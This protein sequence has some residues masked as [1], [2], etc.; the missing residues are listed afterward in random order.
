MKMRERGG[1]E[2]TSIETLGKVMDPGAIVRKLIDLARGPK[3][4]ADKRADL[5]AMFDA[6][7]YLAQLSE[8][9][10]ADLDPLDH[11]LEIGWRAGLDP[12]PRFST[13]FYLEQNADVRAA[14]LN[15]LAHYVSTGW[16]EGRSPSPADRGDVRIETSSVIVAANGF[17]LGAADRACVEALFD[18]AHYKAQLP[19]GC[20]SGWDPLGHYLLNWRDNGAAPCAEFDPAFYLARNPDVAAAGQ[21]PFIH[22]ALAGKAEGRP[23][24]HPIGWRARHL[25]DLSSPEE[26]RRL[27]LSGA[28][29]AVAAPEE[30]S[31]RIDRAC[32]GGGAIIVALSHDNYLENVGGL[33]ACVGIEQQAFAG[34]GASYLQASPAQPLPTLARAEIPGDLVLTLTLDGETLGNLPAGDLAT[35]LS[36]RR[37]EAVIVHSLL[38]FDLDS[39]LLIAGAAPAARRYF[40]V[41]DYLAIC[42][43]YNLMRNDLVYCGAPPPESAACGVCVYG[44]ERRTTAA[45]MRAFFAAFKPIAIA[46]SEVAANI[47][48]R[49]SGCEFED[50]I[51]QAHARMAPGRHFRDAAAAAAEEARAAPARIA[52]LGYPTIAKGWPLFAAALARFG[53]DPRYEFHHFSAAP[54][55]SPARHHEVRVSADRQDAMIDALIE[56]N[57]D[58]A[59]VLS[60]WPETFCIT[61]H[62]AVAAGA[63]LVA[64]EAGG[65]AAHLAQEAG[66]V[67]AGEAEL[68]DLLDGPDLVEA[69]RARRLAGRKTLALEFS[70]MTADRFASTAAAVGGVRA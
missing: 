15:P 17:S 68:L 3:A 65:A 45:A 39:V 37:V 38:G 5:M 22:Y 60:A 23:G 24:A 14:D 63:I 11:Y 69:V 16:K 7:Y 51:V 64:H 36:A 2:A 67:V 48:R 62:E 35:I 31:T 33:Q 42:P 21:D 52:F 43:G 53:N 54:G 26:R 70:G 41:H 46:P 40:W 66:F 58:V 8:P 55:N 19:H 32:A 30:I 6:R 29:V 20:A 25:V 59:F 12:S 18:A 1:G 49:K 27:W 34:R 9:V 57:I 50:I 10:G 28:P 61:A 47:F 56:A 4:V 44:E 13:S